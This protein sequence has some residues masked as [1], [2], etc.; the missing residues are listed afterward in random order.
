MKIRKANKY[1]AKAIANIHV[2]SWRTSYKNIV[3]REY[4]NNLS[5]RKSTRINRKNINNPAIISLV[6]ENDLRE[7]VGFLFGG[8]N[9]YKESA[10]QYS[11]EIYGI[12]IANEYLGKGFGEKLIR[13]FFMLLKEKDIKSVHVMFLAG[14]KAEHFYYKFGARYVSSM[15]YKM[16]DQVYLLHSYGWEDITH[17]DL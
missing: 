2:N 10:K 4:L 6:V 13:H 15:E 7:V 17:L 12:Y 14:N 8:E 9:R 5:V 3:S 16:G 1:D 11:C